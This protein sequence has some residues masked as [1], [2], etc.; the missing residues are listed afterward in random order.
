M[1]YIILQDKEIIGYVD[2]ENTAKLTI[3]KIVDSLNT[4]LKELPDIRVF[5]ENILQG[6]NIYT[7]VLGQVFNGSIVQQHT[8]QWIRVE[9][10]N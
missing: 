1:V 2:D 3:L 5:Q 10:I 9:K 7:Q 8:V 6:V 4:K